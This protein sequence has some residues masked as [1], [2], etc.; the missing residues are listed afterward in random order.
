MITMSLMKVLL[1]VPFLLGGAMA[2]DKRRLIPVDTVVD[3]YAQEDEVFWGRNLGMM[4]ESLSMPT[5]TPPTPSP[6][7]VSSPLVSS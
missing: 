1:V 6:T 4:L 7:P 2:S 5:P 3:E